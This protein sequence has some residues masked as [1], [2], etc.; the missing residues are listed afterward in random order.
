M[1]S[2]A[3]SVVLWDVAEYVL[4]MPVSADAKVADY[5]ILMT[6]DFHLS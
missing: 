4:T 6:N 3:Q 2:P 5:G 1:L